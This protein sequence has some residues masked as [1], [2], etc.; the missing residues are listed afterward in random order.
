[1]ENPNVTKEI[2]EVKNAYF[3]GKPITQ[4]DSAEA[5]FSVLDHYRWLPDPVQPTIIMEY[6]KSSPEQRKKMNEHPEDYAGFWKNEI[7]INYFENKHRIANTNRANLEWL[8][9]LREK[10]P[11]RAAIIDFKIS[12]FIN[13]NAPVIKPRSDAEKQIVDTFNGRIISGGS[14]GDYNE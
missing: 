14:N 2:E 11:E 4:K 9:W 1:M 13:R 10:L 5:A 7:V 3:K 6:F 8:Q 12:Q